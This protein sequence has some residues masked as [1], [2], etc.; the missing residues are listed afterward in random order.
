MRVD[1]RGPEGQRARGQPIQRK[2]NPE[3]S[4]ISGLPKSDGSLQQICPFDVLKTPCFRE[5]KNLAKAPPARK[6]SVKN[7]SELT[8]PTESST[9]RQRC[10]LIL[11]AFQRRAP[12]FRSFRAN[13]ETLRT[14]RSSNRIICSIGCSLRLGPA[15]IAHL[16][17]EIRVFVCTGPGENEVESR[18]A[19]GP[20]CCSV[21]LLLSVLGLAL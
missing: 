17:H 4:E 8:Q 14:F 16:V 20:I 19:K 12:V 6:V 7:Q 3:M 21:Y 9:I 18:P 1:A 10:E 11:Y 5:N 13:E 2:G 15:Q